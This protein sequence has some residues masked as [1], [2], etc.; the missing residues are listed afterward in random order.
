MTSGPHEESSARGKKTVSRED[1]LSR[2]QRFKCRQLA[3]L[4]EKEFDQLLT[5]VKVSAD[6]LRKGWVSTADETVF[7]ED[8]LLIRA[9]QALCYPGDA[10]IQQCT[11]VAKRE[12][13]AA[14]GVSEPSFG[15]GASLGI[16]GTQILGAL[17]QNGK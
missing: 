12:G 15:L 14:I 13:V 10:E 6:E 3:S 2:D 7:R 9:K 4:E 17:P 8:G 5:D 11:Q 1:D 16:H